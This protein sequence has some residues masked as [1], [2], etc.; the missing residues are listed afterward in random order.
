MGPRYWQEL[1][2]PD[3]AAL[4]HER[5]VAVLPVAATEQH[6]PHLPLGVDAIINR[7][8]L[9]RAVALAADGPPVLVLPPL[10]VG[11]SPE[12][13]DFP[14]TL[15]LSAATM[16][17][18]VREIAAGVLRAGL[19]K[20]MFFNSH[21]GQPQLLELAAQELRAEHGAMAMVVNSWRLMRTAE[22]FPAAEIR[23]GIHAGAIE[24]SI[25]LH[26]APEL[27]RRTAVARFASAARGLGDAFPGLA[28]D[29]RL[30]YAWQTQDLNSAGAVG[31]ATLASAEKGRALVEQAAAALVGL[32]E[33]LS[34]LPRIGP[35]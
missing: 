13:R 10:D 29:G 30:A 5:T 9:A 12:H 21:G 24:T 31:D 4:D 11:L 34:R 2:H 14:G 32:W 28:P 25:L 35:A 23:E 3:F 6:G 15:T 18:L 1:A 22:L 19:A 8:I 17:P 16:L 20:L 26:L 33:E 7:A 27:V